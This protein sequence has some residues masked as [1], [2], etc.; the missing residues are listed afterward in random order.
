VVVAEK[1]LVAVLRADPAVNPKTIA[2]PFSVASTT[3]AKADNLL[4][5]AQQIAQIRVAQY[6]DSGTEQAM[7][8]VHRIRGRYIPA[9][10]FGPAHVYV[11]GAPAFGVDFIAKA[12]GAFPW[13][14]A[15]VLVISY[16]V[17]LRAFRSVL[18]P[19]KAVLMNLL[20]VAASYGAL[21]LFFKHGVGQALFGFK[22]SSQIDGWIPIFLFAV[23][24]GLSMDYEVFLLSRM[25]EEW[26][27]HHD[28]EHAVAFGLEHTGRIITAAAIV[29][30]A[31]FSGFT[32]GRFVGF[33]EFGTG[34]SAAILFDATVVRALL[35]P[36]AM[37]LLG[38]WN[39]Y[40]PE[41]V[42]RAMRV[43][44]RPPAGRGQW[45]AE[46]IAR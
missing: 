18:L 42:R 27:G 13:L 32:T 39:W 28:N 25:R 15:A 17:L 2:A 20:S 1:R 33:Q 16:L 14:I 37:K 4:D 36:A 45:T 38:R 3:R 31:A 5:P 46:E 22:T 21:V 9:A 35:V 40:L 29:M 43:P 7:N 24:F 12:Y 34:L 8:L 41:G 11:T 19:I 26:D 23:L 6:Q 30:I 10:G 44:L